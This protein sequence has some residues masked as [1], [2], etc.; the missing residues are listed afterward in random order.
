MTK[1]IPLPHIG[2]VLAEEFMEPLNISQSVLARALGVPRAR[3]SDIV[4]GKRAVTADTDLRLC[5]Y[6]SLS[7]GYFLGIQERIEILATRR[8]IAS[9]IKKIKPAKNTT[10]ASST[11]AL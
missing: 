1:Y 8:K 10:G 11:H 6:F 7:D 9:E 2:K 3:I 5:K 4:N